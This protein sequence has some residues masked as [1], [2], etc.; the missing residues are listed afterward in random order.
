M[1]LETAYFAPGAATWKLYETYT[2]F[3]FWL[4]YVKIWRYSQNRKYIV[5]GGPSRGY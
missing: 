2:S 4:H 3:W 5:G 1:Q